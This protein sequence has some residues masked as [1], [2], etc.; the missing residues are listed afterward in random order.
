MCKMSKSILNSL[1]CVFAP[2]DAA[3]MNECFLG[4]TVDVI[5]DL[6]SLLRVSRKIM[7]RVTWNDRC[8]FSTPTVA[9][10][11]R[12]RALIFTEKAKNGVDC[13]LCMREV[14]MLACY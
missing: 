9:A 6:R 4:S 2:F 14:Y 12:Y 8:S 13:I 5:H 3:S 1:S 11:T 10:S 7:R